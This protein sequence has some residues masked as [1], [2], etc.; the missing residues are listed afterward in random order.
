MVTEP[1]VPQFD[2][3]KPAASAR[4]KSEE[5]RDNFS[6]VSRANDLRCTAQVPADLTVHVE[7]GAYAITSDS[8]KRFVGGDSP[9]LVISGGLAT[10]Q[11]WYVLELDDTGNL[12]WNSNSSWAYASPIVPP[13]NTGRIPLCEVLII[14]GDIAIT[15]DKVYDARPMINLGIGTGAGQ[16]IDPGKVFLTAAPG[17]TWPFDTSSSFTY[18]TGRDEILVWSDAPGFPG[19]QSSGLLYRVVG[20]D[21]VETNNHLVTFTLSIPFAGGERVVIWKVGTSATPGSIALNSLSDVGAA[22]SIDGGDRGDALVPRLPGDIPSSTNLYQT[23]YSHD[24]IDHLTDVPSLVPVDTHIATVASG[25]HK[26]M[27]SE[28]EILDPGI[29]T[30]AVDVQG[31]LDDVET[32]IYQKYIS[33]HDSVTGGHGPKVTIIQSNNDNALVVNET[34]A[35][36]NNALVVNNSGTGA[37]IQINQV[38]N[39]NALAITKTSTDANSTVLVT[40]SSG[41]GVGVYV[42]N[43]GIGD[44]I[45]VNT[46]NSGSGIKVELPTDGCNGMVVSKTDTTVAG[47]A[48]GYCLQISN[49]SGA[50]PV[51]INQFN[52]GNVPVI[53]VANSGTGYIL[54][55]QHK[56]VLSTNPVIN[57]INSGTG[58]DIQ[59][60]N[61]SITK[62]GG[63]QGGV[64]LKIVDRTI[65]SGNIVIDSGVGMV[66][67][68]PQSGS[69]DTLNTMTG[70]TD[71]QVV[72]LSLKNIGQSVTMAETGALNS[73]QDGGLQ[74]LNAR[75]DKATYVYDATISP[76]TWCQVAFIDNA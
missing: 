6:S 1:H 39:G 51:V 63:F 30:S 76:A 49:S 38:G 13:Y 33:E 48:S 57:I 60:I 2:T 3:N 59:G 45:R 58:K 44:S 67:L 73:F 7:A 50:T 12:V 69:S 41:T 42:V 16:A 17:Q 29:Y 18:A 32:K 28:I 21:Y 19:D 34:S 35:S 43:K 10:Q 53:D 62:P 5:M 37:G 23:K 56:N 47:L 8:T 31:A 54:N 11:R 72:I 25:T 74:T 55:L 26:H 22:N 15:Q 40:V 52:V 24:L 46:S 9:I 70:G 4:F 14:F 61:W 71:G 27:A 66:R 65:S 36:S 20:I 64:I 75:A 68:V